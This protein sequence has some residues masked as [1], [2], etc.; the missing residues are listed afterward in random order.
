[1]VDIGLGEGVGVEL[2]AE[3]VGDAVSRRVGEPVSLCSNE[4]PGVYISY[5]F[6]A[7]KCSFCNFASG[8]FPAELAHAYIAA[9]CHEIETHDWQW[10]PDTVYL[11]GG[12]P[13]LISPED[14]T[15]LLSPVPGRRWREA[16]IE[17]APG[18]LG[19]VA[20]WKRAG[21]DRVS[22]GV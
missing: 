18:S 4:V 6:C 8:V 22:L 10:T 12:T 7:Q 2:D 17:A 20:D 16:T 14:L 15:R 21:I 1:M 11:G 13:S 9:L 5:P 19:D 3:L